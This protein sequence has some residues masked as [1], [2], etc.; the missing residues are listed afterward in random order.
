MKDRKIHKLKC[1]Q[2]YFSA[3]KSGIKTFEWRLNDRDFKVGDRLDLFEYDSEK[4]I[5]SGDHLYK[6]VTYILELK[7]TGFVI[8]SIIDAEY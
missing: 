6:E 3:V 2:P 8:M 1:V 5:Y 7:G 4:N